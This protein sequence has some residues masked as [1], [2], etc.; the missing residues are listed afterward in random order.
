MVEFNFK[1]MKELLKPIKYFYPMYILGVIIS[2]IMW[3]Y[4]QPESH[5][6]LAWVF[7][8][9]GPVT[10]IL[11]LCFIHPKIHIWSYHDQIERTCRLCGKKQMNIIQII[12]DGRYPPLIDSW[13]DC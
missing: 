10:H 7:S 3:F 8:L 9:M 4:G 1:L 5:L 6:L 12:N 2:L 13:M 11:H